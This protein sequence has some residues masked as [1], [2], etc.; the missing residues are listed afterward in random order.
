M[1]E[2]LRGGDGG[3]TGRS[4]LEVEGPA[5][6]INASLRNVGRARCRQRAEEEREEERGVRAK[7]RRTP[8]STVSTLPAAPPFG[9]SAGI[10][11]RH[12][13]LNAERLLLQYVYSLK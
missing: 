5:S 6:A 13:L 10:A 3:V 1:R 8:K 9:N 12:F 2:G 7:Y 11:A 4:M